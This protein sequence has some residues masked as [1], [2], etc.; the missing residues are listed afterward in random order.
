MNSNIPEIELE[1]VEP[2]AP[3]DTG[4]GNITL[5]SNDIP[6][7]PPPAPPLP[8]NNIPEMQ[9][10]PT[11]GAQQ[12]VPEVALE[13]HRNFQNIWQDQELS[14]NAQEFYRQRDGEQLGAREAI[15]KFISDRTWRD[16]NTVSIGRELLDI[17]GMDDAQKQRLA[18]LRQYWDSLPSFWQP[19]GRGIR[20]LGENVVKGLV[21][22]AIF[23]GPLAG[24]AASAVAGRGLGRLAQAGIS[25]G[26]DAAVSAGA[27]VATQRAEQEVG[28]RQ[29]ID[30]A[31]AA[32]AGVIGGGA[33]AAGAAAAAILPHIRRQTTGNPVLDAQRD[34]KIGLPDATQ[35]PATTRL[36]R[37]TQEVFDRYHPVGQ[38]QRDLTGVDPSARGYAN[39][40]RGLSPTD[41][42]PINLPWFQMRLRAASG[43]RARDMLTDGGMLPPEMGANLQDN[44]FQRNTAPALVNVVRPLQEQGQLENWGMYMMA[45]RA[46]F[47][48]DVVNPHKVNEAVQAEAQRLAQTN[49]PQHQ[50]QAYL[51]RAA[52][53]ARMPTF[54]DDAQSFIDAG[55]TND[56]VAAAQMAQRSVDEW[57]QFGD[58]NPAFRQAAAEYRQ[59]MDN[60]LEYQRR[61][62]VIS[63]DDVRRIT[64]QHIPNPNNVPFFYGPM[65]HMET[66][67]AT[68]GG[69]GGSGAPARSRFSGSTGNRQGLVDATA[70][71]TFRAV[72]ASDNN[73]AKLAFYDMLD[74]GIRSGQVDPDQIAQRIR[75]DPNAALQRFYQDPNAPEMLRRAGVYTDIQSTPPDDILRVIAAN[76][77]RFDPHVDI[78]FRDGTPEFWRVNDP[79]FLA[80]LKPY[81]E[82]DGLPAIFNLANYMARY[83]STA[84][85]A[86][87]LF[88]AKNMIRD[89]FSSAFNSAHGFTPVASTASALPQALMAGQEYRTALANGLG[90]SGRVENAA[91]RGILEATQMHG[92]GGA[93]RQF[94]RNALSHLQTNYFSRGVEGYLNLANRFEQA[95]RLAEYRLARAAGASEV[96]AA[97]MG[98][99]VATDFGGRG[100]NQTIG[101]LANM[102]AF[103]NAGLQGFYKMGNTVRT[104]P[105][106]VAALGLAL[107]AADA[108]IHALNSGHPDY[109]AI[110][111]IVR[112]Q[113]VLIPIYA[114]NSEAM[115]WVTGQQTEFRYRD[116]SVRNA[117]EVIQFIPIPKPFEYGS[118]GTVVN[119]VLDAVNRG[120][121]QQA[122]DAIMRAFVSNVPGFGTPDILQPV[123]DL[124]TNRDWQNNPITPMSVERNI[125]VERYTERTPMWA[126]Q[127]SELLSWNTAGGEGRAQ[128]TLVSPIEA[129]Y[130][131]NWL[132]SG[133]LNVIPQIATEMTHNE[134]QRG[135]R[136]EARGDE[137][138]L[139]RP[140]SWVT[141][142]FQIETPLRNT[143]NLQR[144]YDLRQRV[145]S[146]EQGAR[147]DATT[148]Y[149][150]LELNPNSSSEEV[151]AATAFSG[152]INNSVRMMQGLDQAA[153]YWRS[154]PDPNI[155]AEMKTARIN[156]ILRQRDDLARSV[157]EQIRTSRDGEVLFRTLLNPHPS[158]NNRPGNIIRDS[159]LGPQMRNLFGGSE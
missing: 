65:Y 49:V 73:R 31:Q 107:V 99:E 139:N 84:I 63:A 88:V 60:Q 95:S 19:G 146:L 25:V 3:V 94:Y 11:T 42:D 119:G 66:G 75:L 134:A 137:V 155:T 126:R 133:I 80:A 18:Y 143:E 58:N 50:V 47:I 123:V 145:Q 118:L 44:R 43:Y 1:P 121:P 48:R 29:N 108:S 7:P 51:D 26:A 141:R 129:E 130:I 91:V 30:P 97:F 138:D 98:R 20:G 149:R 153:S 116:G 35:E 135:A 147:Q 127:I 151:R 59:I 101:T 82:S 8:Q 21:D 159:G 104:Q 4:T 64:W 117:P 132:F 89:T 72:N 90:F 102:T 87:P 148:F 76:N 10:E 100:S 12:N 93:V 33:S 120:N 152:A 22:P 113:N 86:N 38:L 77:W 142:G 109:E 68:G 85:T 128:Q 34:T 74:A 61:S 81:A 70:E 24:R 92:G 111:A 57:I 27:N 150:L 6:L 157:L 36:E 125:G 13:R 15:E 14:R 158:N 39:A 5:A 53:G 124:Y 105:G 62:G 110:P 78:V 114:N 122:S 54:F 40:L 56:P 71:Y 103:F 79:A 136:P 112:G 55:I 144:F 46:R 96:G 17:R 23:V 140:L 67:S 106:H 2:V 37:L 83:R 45:L 52:R 16:A 41:N 115:R 32:L 156:E 69:A 28:M 9:L 154:N 131:G